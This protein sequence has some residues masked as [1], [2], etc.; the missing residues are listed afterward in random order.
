MSYD[1]DLI[2]LGG[3]SIPLYWLNDVIH[4]YPTYSELTRQAARAAYIDR[5]S[6]NPFVRFVKLFRR[7]K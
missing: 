3:G 6:S 5:I 2:I 7:S 4:T 1:Y